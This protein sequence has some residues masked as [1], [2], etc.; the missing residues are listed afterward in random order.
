MDLRLGLAC[1]NQVDELDPVLDK[2]D[3]DVVAND[4]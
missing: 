3:W 2:E 4:V 1:M